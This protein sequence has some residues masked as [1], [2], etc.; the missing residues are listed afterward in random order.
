MGKW[1][2]TPLIFLGLEAQAHKI[3]IMM[4][5]PRT[6]STAFERSMMARGDHK[7]FHEPW[8]SEYVYRKQLGTTP[9]L[10][11]AEAGS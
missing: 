8:N 5:V 9:A 7:V 11:I 3:E 1:L 4:T 6:V 10:E 2:L